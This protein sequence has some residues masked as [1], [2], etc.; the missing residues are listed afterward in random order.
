MTL[1]EIQT[2][3]ETANIPVAYRFFPASSLPHVPFIVWYSDGEAFFYADNRNYKG[4]HMIA[5]ELYTA[6]KD[7]DVEKT[8]ESILDGIA[9]YTKYEAY[10]DTNECYQIRY[11]MEV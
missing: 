2:R 5:I 7:E 1:T 11:E 4:F 10:I 8:L 3:L 6:Q 9:P